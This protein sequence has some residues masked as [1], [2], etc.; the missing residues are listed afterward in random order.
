MVS[1]RRLLL[2]VGILLLAVLA[3]AYMWLR[4]GIGTGP[5]PSRL[6]VAIARRVRSAAIPAA[7][8]ALPNPYA[9]N[10]EAWRL[11]LDRF[12]EHCSLCHDS[13]GR[14]QAVVGRSLYPRAPDMTLPATQEMTDGEIYYIIRNG[15]R[16]T[17]MPGW[18]A[19][20]TEAES[21]QL[22]S[23]IRHLPRLTVE[24]LAEQPAPAEADTDATS[25]P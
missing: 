7:A 9:G 17:G 12:Q 14:G 20:Q 24:E 19:M 15:V 11:G 3:V 1:V 10:R 21:W 16:L 13:D 4:D 23:F 8:R 2:V 25:R 6:E 18:A 22:V 5:E